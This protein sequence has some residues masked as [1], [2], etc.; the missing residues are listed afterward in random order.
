MENIIFDAYI[1]EPISE[2]RQ[3]LAPGNYTLQVAEISFAQNKSGTG[4][5]IKLKLKEVESGAQ[6]FDYFNVKNVVPKTEAWGIAKF[7]GFQR[8]VA[9]M[10]T[11]GAQQEKAMKTTVDKLHFFVGLKVEAKLDVEQGEPYIKHI[12]KPDGE[13]VAEQRE[14]SP[15]NVIKN[16]LIALAPVAQ[17]IAAAQVANVGVVKEVKKPAWG[18]QKAAPVVAAIEDDSDN[19]PY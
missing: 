4:S 13:T 9:S 3:V 14:S 15:Q 2:K 16:Y 11:T 17:P 18:Q 12:M 10:L 5:G 7:S 6:L 1:T 19:I 8:A